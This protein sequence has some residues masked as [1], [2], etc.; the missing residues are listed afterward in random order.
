MEWMLLTTLPVDSFQAACQIEN[1]QLG[2]GDRIEGC[3]A[4][5]LVVAWRIFHLCKLG[6][7]TF[8]THLN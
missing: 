6:R 8:A 1:R 7:K 4:I 5:D 3:L 2:L